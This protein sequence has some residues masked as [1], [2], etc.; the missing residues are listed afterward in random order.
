MS[1]LATYSRRYCPWIMLLLS[2][3]IISALIIAISENRNPEL[4]SIPILV[5]CF[6]WLLLL[7]NAFL[8]G[9][10][11]YIL[12]RG[13][14]KSVEQISKSSMPLDSL[15]G[16]T[17][18]RS[19]IGLMFQSAYTIF[20]TA[21][22]SIA[23]FIGTLM[24]F[25]Q[26]LFKPE[27]FENLR[28]LRDALV[29]A[30]L[31]MVLATLG[32]VALIH[33][34]QAPAA[35]P[36]G[37]LGYYSPR[38]LPSTLDNLLADSVY[39][40]LDPVTRL[41]FDEWTDSIAAMMRDD[42][43]P[44]AD[45]LSR[46]ERAR[47]KILLMIYL[48]MRMPNLVTEEAYLNELLEVIREELCE[49]FAEGRTSG[50]PLPLM[51]QVIER[52]QK[53]IPEVFEVI[54]RLIVNLIDNLQK[55]KETELFVTM[56]LPPSVHG[57]Q[58]PFRLLLLILNKSPEF[59]QMRRPIRIVVDAEKD[60]IVPR[61]TEINL[62]LDRYQGLNIESEKLEIIDREND[63]EED[64]VRLLSR[65]LQMSD[66]AW[67]QFIPRIYGQTILNVKIEEPGKGIIYGVTSDI[68]LK[69]DLRFFA[70]TY[71]GRVSVL[72]GLII[73]ALNLF[74]GFLPF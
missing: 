47:E 53:E 70:K 32:L 37:L 33:L 66:A 5:A 30:A 13:F 44:D 36:G 28:W 25:N 46:L 15:D 67:V 72:G 73:P 11:G 19:N 27:E 34:P 45:P 68:A 61:R 43:E 57:H 56:G 39:P 17:E 29:I 3:G 65:I 8:F 23:I 6:F 55:F 20:G 38:T 1:W 35:V 71:G 42:F 22:I 58:N 52:L 54:D 9:I 12:Y 62:A 64:I 50:F 24:V 10:N 63:S 48:H 26:D 69:R 16:F 60:V 14:E 40:F 31:G 4:I 51:E 49:D 59:S 2:G 74:F 7:V 18:T 41:L 21:V